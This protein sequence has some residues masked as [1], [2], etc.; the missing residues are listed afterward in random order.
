MLDLPKKRK[1]NGNNL[2]NDLKKQCDKE[3][4]DAGSDNQSLAGVGSVQ[5]CRSL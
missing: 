2:E 5:P 3:S 1:V 4:A